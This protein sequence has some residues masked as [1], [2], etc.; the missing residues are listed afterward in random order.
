MY[1]YK[2]KKIQLPCGKNKGNKSKKSEGVVLREVFVN[3]WLLYS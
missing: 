2:N 1:G 3:Y